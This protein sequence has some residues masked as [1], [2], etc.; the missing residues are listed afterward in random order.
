MA[1]GLFNG[2]FGKQLAEAGVLAMVDYTLERLVEIFGNDLRKALSPVHL[3]ADWDRDPSILGYVSAALPGRAD[4]RLDLAR[5]VDDRLFFAGE[6]TSSQFMGDV[7]GA[8]LS[9]IDAA[10]AAARVV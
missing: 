6:A 9:G 4:A 8:W 2:P 5:A 10:D 1:V 7:H 3:F